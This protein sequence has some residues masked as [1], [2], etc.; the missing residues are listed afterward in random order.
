MVVAQVTTLLGN[1]VIFFRELC[2]DKA[3]NHFDNSDFKLNLL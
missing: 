2:F 1:L 3:C